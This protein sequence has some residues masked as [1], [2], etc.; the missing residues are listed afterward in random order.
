[1]GRYGDEADAVQS[2]F[3]EPEPRPDWPRNTVDLHTHTNRSDGVLSPEELYQAMA[4][5]GLE[6]VAVSDH[7]TLNGL[8]ALREAGLGV[9]DGAGPQII[10]AVE[11]N[12]IAD[13]ELINM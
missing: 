4:E 10:P 7:D 11:I 12:S 8:R 9:A 1:M 2:R 3:R 6:V 5:C 13:R